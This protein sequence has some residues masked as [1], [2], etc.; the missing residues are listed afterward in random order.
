MKTILTDIKNILAIFVIG[1]TMIFYMGVTFLHIKPDPDI[2]TNINA[3]AVMA[4]GYF[5][6]ASSSSSKKDETIN[7][8]SKKNNN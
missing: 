5:F 8:L 3:L 2:K 7:E 6:I 1:C 4:M